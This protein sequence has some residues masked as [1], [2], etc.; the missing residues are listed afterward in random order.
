MEIIK[1]AGQQNSATLL[2]GTVVYRQEKLFVEDWGAMVLC[3]PYDDHFIYENPDTQ[4]GSPGYM[5]TCGAVAVVAPPN[6]FGLFVCLFDL[7]NELKGYHTT[8][9]YNKDEFDKVK[10]QTLDPGNIRK[11]L[12]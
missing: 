4:K 12:I 10:G 2:D 1:H 5:C 6:R 8:S 9:L 11:E 7:N 3:A